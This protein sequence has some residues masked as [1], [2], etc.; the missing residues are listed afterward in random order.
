MLIGAS[1]L[2]PCTGSLL[3]LAGLAVPGHCGAGSR[4]VCVLEQVVAGAK[5][6]PSWRGAVD[7]LDR[8]QDRIAAQFEAVVAE[9][10]RSTFSTSR[11][12]PGQLLLSRMLRGAR[13]PAGGAPGRCR[14]R[15]AVELAQLAVSG[16]LA[17]NSRW[18]GTV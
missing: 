8:E 10:Y 17:S 6:M 4:T 9:T 15:A 5:R 18:G 12:D 13:R 11:A 7:H 14:Q 16:R 3:G 1:A 2:S